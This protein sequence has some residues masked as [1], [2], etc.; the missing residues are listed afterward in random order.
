MCWRR[1]QQS[2]AWDRQF[3][4]ESE[5]LFKLRTAMPNTIYIRPE[6]LSFCRDY[7]RRPLGIDIK[8]IFVSLSVKEKGPCALRKRKGPSNFNR[9]VVVMFIQWRTST[10]RSWLIQ[11]HHKILKSLFQQSVLAEATKRIK[12][13]SNYG[14]KRSIL[15]TRTRD[16]PHWG[17]LM[18]SI[19]SHM[20]LD[21]A[22]FFCCCFIFIFVS[23]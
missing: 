23:F 17:I 5:I 6:S 9:N 22:W 12:M 10:M 3:F 1:T 20:P 11:S 7:W 8:G 18:W 19:T 15:S 21:K 4:V 14:G 16:S 2:V 13:K